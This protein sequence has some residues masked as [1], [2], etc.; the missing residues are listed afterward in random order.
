M[1]VFDLVTQACIL[2]TSRTHNTEQHN[3]LLLHHAQVELAT[4]K[5]EAAELRQQLAAAEAKQAA[6]SADLHKTQQQLAQAQLQLK[7]GQTELDGLKRLV[8]LLEREQEGDRAA[9]AGAA[10]ATDISMTEP[11]SA[12]VKIEGLQALITV[13]QAAQVE[14]QA[15]LKQAMDAEAAAKAGEAAARADLKRQE[16]ELDE[17][18]ATADALQVRCRVAQASIHTYDFIAEAVPMQ[19]ELQCQ[20]ASICTASTSV[21]SSPYLSSVVASPVS[22]HL[23]LV[24]LISLM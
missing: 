13:L 15:Q 23:T 20:A 4:T 12:A 5:A 3:A 19:R 18:A 1:S 8:T 9:A 21:C 2:F 6:A 24:L 7:L 10:G 11:G 17:V 22:T 14:L 16:R